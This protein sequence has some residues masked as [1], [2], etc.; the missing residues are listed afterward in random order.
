ME[1]LIPR[2]KYLEV[3]NNVKYLVLG[4]PKGEEEL[5][6]RLVFMCITPSFSDK[7][8]GLEFYLRNG[9]YCGNTHLAYILARYAVVESLSIHFLQDWLLKGNTAAKAIQY[10]LASRVLPIIGREVYPILRD[11]LS[12]YTRN[13]DNTKFSLILVHQK[14]RKAILK[15]FFKEKG[16]HKRAIDI[17][18]KAVDFK[19]G[20][21]FL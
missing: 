6:G 21:R 3:R 5:L 18:L 1:L 9:L 11:D 8:Y 17:A 13:E 7:E 16:F 2:S 15:S 20:R 14:K 10:E 19:R 4:V 12:E